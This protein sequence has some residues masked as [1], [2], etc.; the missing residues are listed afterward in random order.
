MKKI[1]LLFFL[2]LFSNFYSQTI[3]QTIKGTVIDKQ[4]QTPIPGAIVQL[5]N[6]DPIL[7]TST[8]EKGEFKIANV[9]IGR[10]QIKFQV[11]SYKEKYI[12][13]I[14]NAGKES[15]STVELEESVIQGQEVVVTAE[16]DKTKTNNKM[17]TVSSR[18]FSA[19]EAARYAGSRNDP[20]R[21]AANFAGVSGAND[22]RNDIIIR[23]N[24]PIGILWRLNGLDIPNPNH[25][26]NAGSTGGPVS[27]LNNNTL[28]NSDFM[29]G[30]FAADYGNA[31]SGVF[32]LKMRQGNNEKH[33]YL[34]QMGFNGFELGAEGP[35][36]KKK[37][38]SFLF[39]YRYSTLAVFKALNIDFG[40]GSA[41][42]QYQD[43]TFKTD[44]NTEKFGK[45]SF[46]GVGGLS[47][48]ALLDK[49]K[50]EG[51]DLVGY[52]ARDTYFRS[53]VGATGVSHTYLFKNN[54]YIKTNMGVSGQYNNVVADRIDTSFKTPNNTKPEYRQ[55]TQNIR[56]SFNT[57]YNKK[58]NSR[59]FMNVGIYTELYN[60]LFVDSN[61]NL[62][63]TNT[64]VTLRNYKGTTALVRGFVQ[65]QHKFTDNLLIN[66]GVSNQFFLLN[67]SNAIEPRAGLKYSINS[68][69]SI[70]IGGGLHSQLQPIYIYFASDS[71]N[72]KRVETNR[73]LDFTRAA[74]GVL[75][76]DNSF[77][78]NFRLKAELYYQYIYNAPVQNF[79]SY[80]SA[81]NLGADFNSP[82]VNN[83][84]SKGTG[85]NY[86]IEITLE[87]FYSKGYYILCTSSLFESKYRGSDNIL[88]NTAFN[89]NYVFNLLGGKEFKINQKHVLSIDV[90]GT[91]AGGKRYTPIDLEASK[92]YGDEVRDGTRA[93][94]FKYADYFRLDVKPGYRFNSKKVTHE[95]TIDVQNVT[96]NANVFQQS[97]DIKNQ[98]IKT[99]YQL[100]FFV[101]PQ[102]R[103]L[104]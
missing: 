63:G 95:F 33:E 87:K 29:S 81:L 67:N 86:G 94:E 47:Y 65:W 15:V 31:T 59:D 9:P 46:W 10:W 42:P 98:T 17:S 61:D 35:F 92:A 51:Q 13:V 36:N 23:G 34:V 16:Q 26:G 1:S 102:Y 22:S 41:V 96:R 44:F 12:T 39:N 7:G 11:I 57:T 49:D 60:T 58:F 62:F 8:N 77:A 93:Y 56:Y 21:M 43:I 40:T 45:F 66:A 100:R 71:L 52:S 101:I 69:Q 91:Y 64:F 30:A 20:A 27:I 97:Y 72:G 28:D 37:N 53:N 80:F 103:L 2:F 83:L 19:E 14:L 73:D 18:L 75:A 99:D 74:H 76:Y 90:R 3:T 5:L 32:D 48:I 24:S 4:S 88:R 25:F 50:K 6:S 78:T 89:G 70:S 54:A 84:V 55:T 79:P 85:E 82:N 104:F 38:S 68:K